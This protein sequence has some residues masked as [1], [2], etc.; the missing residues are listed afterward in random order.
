LRGLSDVRSLA[1]S[2]DGRLLAAGSY[3]SPVRVWELAT[4]QEICTYRGHTGPI[5]SVAF[6]PDGTRVAT[7]ALEGNV[8]IWNAWTGREL[9][10]VR[11]HLGAV[12]GVAFSPDGRRL[13]SGSFDRTIKLWDVTQEQDARDIS[14]PGEYPRASAFSGD[15]RRLAATSGSRQGYDPVAR[16][17]ELDSGQPP[18]LFR[19]H[20]AGVEDAAFSPDRQN[21]ATASADGT[22][23]V[24]EA[25]TAR[26]LR[27]LRGH[28]GPVSRLAYSPDG[29]YLASAGKDKTI[30]IWNPASGR[31]LRTIDF[32]TG[33]AT[34]IDFSPDSRR[35]ATGSADGTV[36]LWDVETGDEL[37][38]RREKGPGRV[39]SV[40]FSPDGRYLAATGGDELIRI[41]DLA[42]EGATDDIPR[43]LRGHT[44]EV[45]GLSFSHDGRRLASAGFDASVKIWEPASGDQILSLPSH[46]LH[47]EGVKFSPDGRR[48]A[49]GGA[50][51][52]I[53]EGEATGRGRVATSALEPALEW[54][55]QQASEFLQD[56]C[57]YGAIFHLDQVLA[58]APEMHDLYRQRSRAHAALGQ[59]ASASADSALSGAE[60][61][62]LEGYLH[63]LSLLVLAGD[64][65]GYRQACRSLLE[66]YRQT[67]NAQIA[68]LVARS[69]AL[70]PSASGSANEVDQAMEAVSLARRAVQIVPTAGWRLYALGLAY[71]RVGQY[72]EAARQAWASMVVDPSWNG[73]VLNWLVLSMAYS[74]LGRGNEAQACFNEAVSRIDKTT[75]QLP[76]GQAPF[77]GLSQHN[78]PAWRLLRQEAEA[79]LKKP[80]LSLSR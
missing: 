21:L 60:P 46:L 40:V 17:F 65:Q 8:K 45:T 36:C 73:S 35:L 24:W 2:A 19:G 69:C 10:T 80:T 67:S 5:Y 66:R 44:S 28:Q 41:W 74:R 77:L 56:G 64:R 50:S 12:M 23:K 68:Y 58:N 76:R 51:I 43:T 47:A 33:A 48:L 42:P 20:S 34:C 25:A 31:P 9:L 16:V 30:R 62:S 1:I 75:R 6:A 72:E 22:V 14:I 49:C 61:D 37:L 54:H 63:H 26:E 4:G 57:W 11:G 18:L 13:V 38:P 7:S 39:R 29:A 70:A 32:R 59:W 27:T 79:L 52:R 3:G 55:R 78:W 71:Y 15:G 53:W